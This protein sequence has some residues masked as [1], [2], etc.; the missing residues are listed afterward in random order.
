MKYLFVDLALTY[1]NPTRNLL[2]GLFSFDDISC[3]GPGYV[4]SECLEKG[5]EVFMNEHGPFDAV[6]TTEH[7]AFSQIKPGP[8]TELAYKRNYYFEFP[9][10]EITQRQSIF[11]Q[12]QKLNLYKILLTLESD[13]YNFTTEQIS[14]IDGEFD[15]TVSWGSQFFQKTTNMD[16]KN[17]DIFREVPNDNWLEYSERAFSKI[18]PLHHFVSES[19]FNYTCLSHR[20]KDFVVPGA[21]YLNRKRAKRALVKSDFKKSI[22]TSIPYIGILNRLGVHTFSWPWFQEY[23]QSSF[24]RSIKQSKIAFT[25]GSSLDFPIRKFFEIPAFGTILFCR[26][27]NGFEALGFK[28]Q[29]NAV[30]C[31]PEELPILGAD[32]LSN[33][34]KAQRIATQGRDLIK[35]HHTLRIR[36]KQLSNALVKAINGEWK[37]AVWQDGKLRAR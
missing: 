1:I 12:I 10:A 24:K 22:S 20:P 15:L 32:L 21:I 19:E 5:I 36:A 31:A 18:V 26:P 6:V 9:L 16:K 34:E 27:C 28:D 8:L 3:F 13:Y 2:T 33:P 17:A 35:T 23:Y 4:S 11:K 25:C 29:I 14:I 7:I 37:G 30:V